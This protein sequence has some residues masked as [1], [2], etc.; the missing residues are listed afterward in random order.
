MVLLLVEEVQCA[1]RGATAPVLRSA[2][3]YFDASRCRHR[4]AG[5]TPSNLSGGSVRPHARAVVCSQRVVPTPVSPIACARA[6][7]PLG[8]VDS[9]ESRG[10][11]RA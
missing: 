9:L 2:D 3:V 5:S 7:S 11:S 10:M 4:G 1:Q 6:F 8:N